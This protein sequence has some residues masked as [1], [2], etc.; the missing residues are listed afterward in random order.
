MTAADYV[1]SDQLDLDY[2][3]SRPNGGEGKEK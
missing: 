3:S 2:L 1:A